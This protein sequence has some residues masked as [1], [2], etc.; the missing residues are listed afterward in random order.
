MASVP[1]PIGP[2]TAQTPGILC[3][4]VNIFGK[5]TPAVLVYGTQFSGTPPVYYFETRGAVIASFTPAQIAISGT[6]TN[7]TL[8]AR[9]QNL[10]FNTVAFT[11]PLIFGAGSSTI[12]LKAINTTYQNWNPPS[13]L[14]S[15]IPYQ[16]L[17]TAGNTTIGFYYFLAQ[18]IAT[19]AIDTSPI[20]SHSI[21]SNLWL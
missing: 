15:G 17:P 2:L 12:P 20:V 6:N 9:G 4:I 14:L 7:L 16:L 11:T 1:G 13:I 18:T 19:Y 3:K 8:R 21:Y 10:A 5:L